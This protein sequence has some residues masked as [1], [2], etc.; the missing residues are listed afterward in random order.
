MNL[1]SNN[2]IAQTHSSAIVKIIIGCK[3]DVKLSF[4][5]NSTFFNFMDVVACYF[6]NYFPLQLLSQRLL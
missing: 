3:I 1:F 5:C 6:E 4:F 2:T